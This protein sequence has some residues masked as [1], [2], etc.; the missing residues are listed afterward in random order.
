MNTIRV[1]LFERF[2]LLFNWLLIHINLILV[3][4]IWQSRVLPYYIC[5]VKPTHL[6]EE[7]AITRSTSLAGTWRV[8]CCCHCIPKG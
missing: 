1:R 6:K 3:N 8:S 4:K 5:T 7:T 2:F